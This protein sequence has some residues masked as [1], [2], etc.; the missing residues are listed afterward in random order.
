MPVLVKNLQ[1]ILY[2]VPTLGLSLDPSG[3]ADSVANVTSEI[4]GLS[5]AEYVGLQSE[6]LAGKIVFTKTDDIAFATGSLQL[7]AALSM[8]DLSLRPRAAVSTPASPVYFDSQGQPLK[9]ILV[10]A[11]GAYELEFWGSIDSTTVDNEA[12]RWSYLGK[13]VAGDPGLH[14][15]PPQI[16]NALTRFCYIKADLI[17]GTPPQILF[18][19]SHT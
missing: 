7:Q 18:Q 13:M 8:M 11:P 19:S 2:V 1:N 16:L 3:Q 12:K 5:D 4:Q 17:R 10:D 9:T 14:R 15:V 6:Q